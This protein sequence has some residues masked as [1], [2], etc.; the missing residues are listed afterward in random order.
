M[1]KVEVNYIEKEVICDKVLVFNNI[2]KLN[3]YVNNMLDTYCCVIFITEYD[4]QCNVISTRY[5]D[6]LPF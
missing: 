6:S 5:E 1:Y 4:N 3:E 2:H